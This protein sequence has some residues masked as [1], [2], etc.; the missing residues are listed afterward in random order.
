MYQ[1]ELKFFWPLTEQIPLDLDYSECER[2]K[3]SVPISAAT[4]CVLTPIW[5]NA[6][7]TFT[8]A[9]LNLD[10][11][12]TTVKLKDKPG[13]IRRSLYDCLGLKW[14]LK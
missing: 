1:Q 2:P 5:D 11:E 14:E 12:S 10:V 3:L 7:V 13:F 8:A 4:N 9:H 6:N